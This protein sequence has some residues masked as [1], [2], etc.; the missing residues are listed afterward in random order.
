MLVVGSVYVAALSVPIPIFFKATLPSTAW[1]L[2]GY[3][4]ASGKRPDITALLLLFS[5]HRI[6]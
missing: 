5:E 6:Y 1:G 2:K 4:L 3:I